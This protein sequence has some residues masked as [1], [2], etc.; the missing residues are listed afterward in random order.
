MITKQENELSLNESNKK[1][2]SNDPLIKKITS[3]VNFIIQNKK[4]SLNNLYNNKNSIIEDPYQIQPLENVNENVILINIV[5]NSIL[6]FG[7]KI[8][9]RLIQLLNPDLN[10]AKRIENIKNIIAF[11][12]SL[13]I[14]IKNFK[15]IKTK[16]FKLSKESLYE[17][18]SLKDHYTVFD[19]ANG[20]KTLSSTLK[21][22]EEF[23]I[24]LEKHLAN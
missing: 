4:L 21:C 16:S 23:Y 1:K 3:N 11:S 13:L 18:K 22:L 17:I 9:E 5:F 24:E 6:V 15:D 12:K 20:C 8:D 2:L 19:I 14:K 10:H 7:K